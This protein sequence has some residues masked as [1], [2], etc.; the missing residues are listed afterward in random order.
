[1]NAIKGCCGPRL[2]G[3]TREWLPSPLVALYLLYQMYIIHHR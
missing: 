2:Y 1:M 3:V